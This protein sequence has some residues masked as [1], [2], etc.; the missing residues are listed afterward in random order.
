MNDTVSNEVSTEVLT[1]ISKIVS[2]FETIYRERMRDLPIVNRC[3]QVEAVGFR[4]FGQHRLGV[5]MTPWFMNLLLLPGDE[6]WQSHEQGA[7]CDVELPG[8]RYEFTV[9][10][11][12]ALGTYLSAVLFRTMSDMP[13]QDTARAIAGE[14]LQRLRS[15]PETA[16]QESREAARVFGHEPERVPGARS[17]TISRRELLLGARGRPDA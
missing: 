13:D 1:D 16:E 4:A 9:T 3:L 17:K 5:L 6:C 8:G 10:H 11:D 7:R 14:I 2:H 12:E 15:P